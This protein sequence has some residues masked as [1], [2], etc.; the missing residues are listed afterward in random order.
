MWKNFIYQLQ[1]ILT[2]C[3]EKIR[4]LYRIQCRLI[5]YIQG[6]TAGCTDVVAGMSEGG[7]VRSEGGNAS[8]RCKV[9]HTEHEAVI[10]QSRPTGYIHALTLQRRIGIKRPRFVNHTGY[11]VESK[12][13]VDVI[14]TTLAKAA[15]PAQGAKEV[16][17][18]G[19]D[20]LV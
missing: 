10:L 20:F 6:A 5:I 17:Q 18:N 4:R 8:R 13:R 15:E 11:E 16:F 12:G 2:I 7:S 14:T 3:I 1:P 9:H 19:S